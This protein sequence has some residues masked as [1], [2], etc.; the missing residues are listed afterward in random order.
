MMATIFY[1]GPEAISGLHAYHLPTNSSFLNISFKTNLLFF[2]FLS[3]FLMPTSLIYYL[4]K[5]KI[6]STLTMESLASRRIPYFLTFLLYLFFAFLL[7][8]KLPMLKEIAICLFSVSACLLLVFILSFFWK[9]SAHAMGMAGVLGAFIGFY[10]K[11]GM[12]EFFLPI[13]ITITI[14][15]FVLAARLQLNAHNI[16]QIIVGYLVGFS[17]SLSSILLFL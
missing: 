16:P 11:N 4:Y 1:V 13:L 2:I 8:N 15:G 9:I 17:I 14:S 5:V 7:Q 12:S 6:I 10:I 3:T